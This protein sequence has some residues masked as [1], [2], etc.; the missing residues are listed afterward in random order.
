MSL[1]KTPQNLALFNEGDTSPE[2]LTP[3]LPPTGQLIKGHDCV[4]HPG[5]LATGPGKAGFLRAK[6]KLD[7][8]K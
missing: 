5:G 6:K 2:T 8:S 3:P 4:A 7:L 1:I